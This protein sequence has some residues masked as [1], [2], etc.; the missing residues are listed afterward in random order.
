MQ[1]GVWV[2]RK[3][4]ESDITAC[5][6]VI[7][8]SFAT[9]ADTFGLTAEN[10]PRFVAFSVTEERLHQQLL[11]ERRPMYVL[12]TDDS[13]I[14]YYSLQVLDDQR[15][16]LNQ[17]CVLPA[18]RHAGSGEKLLKHA[19]GVAK[20]LKCKKMNIGIVEEN[21]VLRN[22]YESY[23]F[24]HTG[25]RKTDAFPFTCGFMEKNL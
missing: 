4:K 17:L 18:Y 9:V 8:A 1:R 5:A 23:G 7:R 11:E 25:T 15:C 22:W 3:V 6:N 20:V 2:I 24:I 16:E 13:I 10:A 19:F 12:I 14:G 21:K